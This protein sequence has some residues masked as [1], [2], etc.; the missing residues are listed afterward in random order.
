[1]VGRQKVERG[2]GKEDRRVETQAALSD[3]IANLL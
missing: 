3:C 2:E 1:V